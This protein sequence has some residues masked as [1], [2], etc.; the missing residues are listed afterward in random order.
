VG[1]SWQGLSNWKLTSPRK[2]GAGPVLARPGI[3]RY[4]AARGLPSKCRCT[5]GATLTTGALQSEITARQFGT[6]TISLSI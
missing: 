4:K 6:H 5:L 1:C 3:A 2:W